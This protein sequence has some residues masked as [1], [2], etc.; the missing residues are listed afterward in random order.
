MELSSSRLQGSSETEMLSDA[1]ASR[2]RVFG[3]HAAISREPM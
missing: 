1:Y 3:R 2:E